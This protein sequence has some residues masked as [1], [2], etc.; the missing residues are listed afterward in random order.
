MKKQF[1]DD[2]RTIA[3]MSGV[4]RPALFGWR[5]RRREN[6]DALP[7]EDQQDDR[8]W[9]EQMS[10]KEGRMYAL[11]ALTAGLVIAGVFIAAGAIAI[12]IMI[13]VWSH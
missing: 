13:A 6:E 9:E 5:D 8:P 12:A 3:D 2:G 11:G 7:S 1:E 10:K 4:E